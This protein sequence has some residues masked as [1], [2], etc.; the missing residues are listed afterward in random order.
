MDRR[1]I[2]GA[3]HQS[4][5]YVELA[6]QM[7]FADSANRGIARHLPNILGGE[8]EQPNAGATPRSGGRSFASGMAGADHQNVMHGPALAHQCFT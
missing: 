5:E 6:D 3:R 4:V 2:G 8:G 7:S 1:T